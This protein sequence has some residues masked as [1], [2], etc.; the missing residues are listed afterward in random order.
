MEGVGL[1]RHKRN[2]GA[3]AWAGAVLLLALLLPGLASAG[4]GAYARLDGHKVYYTDQGKGE[5]AMVLIHG[6]GG[7]HKFWREQVP[8]L[9]KHHRVIAIDLIGHGQSDKPQ[10]AYSLDYL[11]RSVLA[12]MDAAKVKDAVIMGHSLGAAVA[13]RIAL[14]HPERVRAVIS[15]DGALGRPPLEPTARAKWIAQAKA[16]AA[17]FQGPDGR[18]NVPM[19]V[20]SMHDKQTPPAVRQWIK[21]QIMATPWHVGRS[22]MNEFVQPSSWDLAPSSAPLLAIYVKNQHLTPDF[23]QQLKI[24]FPNLRFKEITGVGHFLMLEKPE[25]IN[26]WIIEFVDSEAVKGRKVGR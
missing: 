10:A 15:M 14:E 12:V 6:W 22:A 5:P 13:R 20:D 9:A 18:K 2:C 7:N 24:L 23:K 11:A 25:V 21:D 19:F 8:A 17:M 4:Q 3:A 1:M 16:F 26:P